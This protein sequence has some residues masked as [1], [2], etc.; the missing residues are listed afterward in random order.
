MGMEKHI[1]KPLPPKAMVFGEPKATFASSK[2]RVLIADE[3]MIYIREVAVR[4]LRWDEIRTASVERLEDR[5]G[6]ERY[7]VLV[8][9]N[10]E[11]K[12]RFRN[13]FENVE[14]MGRLIVEHVMAVIE[15][16]IRQQL[17]SGEWV[18]FGRGTKPVIAL[19]QSEGVRINGDA[20]YTWPEVESL[21][22]EG[23]F[24][25]LHLANG[26]A[27]KLHYVPQHLNLLRRLIDELNH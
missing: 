26:K 11:E 19:H 5:G 9:T 15:P 22:R 21:T 27:H 25:R 12:Y 20:Y 3:G 10:M 8:I 23:F 16:E 6:L 2:D 4:V 17:A 14:A 1:D 24:F 13:E 18:E 7:E